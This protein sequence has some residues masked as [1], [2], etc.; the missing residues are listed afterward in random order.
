M[1][2]ISMAVAG[3]LSLFAMTVTTV[4]G[5]TVIATTTAIGM[6]IYPNSVVS[7]DL[8]F[9]ATSDAS[10]FACLEFD[11]RRTA[12][13]PDK[14]KDGLMAKQ[15]FIFT[16]HYTDGSSVGLWAHPDFRTRERALESVAPAAEAVGKLPTFMRKTLDHVVIHR[17]DE[18]AFGE[19]EGHFFVL[20]SENIKTRIRNHDLEE[21]VF[22][23]SV[24]ATLDKRYATSRKWRKA[25]KADGDFITKY[26]RRL[27]KKE[28]LAESG[29]FAW[30]MI[31]HPGRLPAKIEA[32][33][34]QIMPHRIAFFEELFLARPLFEASKRKPPC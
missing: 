9:I 27:P 8:E 26:A 30:A 32:R 2:H 4:F 19:A 28:D 10:A 3:C 18:T 5:T 20:Y 17:G 7:N 24:H 11:G 29:L 15:T 16:A 31:M 6:P 14:R 34:R 23:E 12:E 25:Q 22:H 1:K 21:T 33:A 13:M